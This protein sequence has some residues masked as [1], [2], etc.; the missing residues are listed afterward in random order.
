MY[1]GREEDR[2]DKDSGDRPMMEN[3]A[4]LLDEIAE[5]KEYKHQIGNALARIEHWQKEVVEPIRRQTL[6]RALS[7]FEEETE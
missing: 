3:T 4:K 7:I 5:L 1:L 2:G 6:E